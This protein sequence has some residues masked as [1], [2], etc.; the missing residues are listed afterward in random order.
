[1]DIVSANVKK[2]VLHICDST[3]CLYRDH[4]TLLYTGFLANT[5]Y[6]GMT[7]LL[8]TCW[9]ESLAGYVVTYDLWSKE[10]DDH[11]KVEEVIAGKP[12]RWRTN[13]FAQD[14][15]GSH[16]IAWQDLFWRRPLPRNMI[17]K[18]STL[19][20]CFFGGATLHRNMVKKIPPNKKNGLYEQFSNP[21][22]YLSSIRTIQL[23]FTDF[24]HL[25]FRVCHT[26]LQVSVQAST[27]YPVLT[28]DGPQWHHQWCNP[29]LILV[30]VAL[31]RN[32]FRNRLVRVWLLEPASKLVHEGLGFVFPSTWTSNEYQ[33]IF[34]WDL[35]P[36]RTDLVSSPKGGVAKILPWNGG[37]WNIR[38]FIQIDLDSWGL[39]QDS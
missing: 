24:Y 37:W 6:D 32:A 2:C 10:E 21:F 29:S 3:T 22:R 9:L 11:S 38:W 39:H 36:S 5:Q 33:W 13:V 26:H 12:K 7:N 25:D 35:K 15:G 20:P 30:I 8:N 14:F 1:M 27:K 31:E 34:G 23:V 4:T 17:L 16:A 28:K 18:V 19:D